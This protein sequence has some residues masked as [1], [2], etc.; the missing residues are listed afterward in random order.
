MKER[1]LE[2][3]KGRRRLDFGG[4]LVGM[5]MDDDGGGSE[6]NWGIESGAGEEEDLFKDIPVGI[7]EFM[8]Q[9]KRLKQRHALE[10]TSGG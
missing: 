9:E 1:G 4:E 2:R 3:V 7:R 5:S 10:G 6:S 8:K